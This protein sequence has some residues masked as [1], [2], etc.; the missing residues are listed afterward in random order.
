MGI[1]IFVSSRIKLK[2][3]RR[4]VKS[5]ITSM[6]RNFEPILFEDE[7]ADSK[8]IKKWWRE[9]IK[10]SNFLVLIIEKELSAAV[11]DEFKTAKE[12]GLETFVF[13]KGKYLNNQ[14]LKVINCP[15]NNLF[16]SDKDLGWFYENLGKYKSIENEEQ[17]KNEIRNAISQKL[18]VSEG[19]PKSLRSSTIK[20]DDSELKRIKEVYVKPKT[21]NEAEK[22]LNK[23]KFLMITGPA[24]VGKTTMAYF[25][26]SKLKENF[27]AFRILKIERERVSELKELSHSVIFFDDVFGKAEVEKRYADQFQD[28]QKL[29]DNNYLIL[30]TRKEILDELK[31]YRTRFGEY[32]ESMIK[33]HVIEIEQ[34]GSYSNEDLFQILRNHLNYYQKIGKIDE[35]EVEF[36]NQ[37]KGLIIFELRFPHNYEVFVREQ[38]KKISKGEIDIEQAIDNAKHIKR[39]AKNWFEHIDLNKKYFVFTVALFPGFDEERFERIY[40]K[41]IKDLKKRHGDLLEEDLDYLRQQTSSYIT[42]SKKIDFKHP[43]YLEGVRE[44]LKRCKRDLIEVLPTFK[45]LTKEK[46]FRDVIAVNLGE[47]GYINITEAL[48]ILKK[49][50]KYKKSS[51][52]WYVANS[53]GKIGKIKPDLILEKLK[54]WTKEEIFGVRW[55]VADSIGKFGKLKPKKALEILRE[56]AEDERA[57]VRNAVARSIGEIGIAIPEKALKILKELTEDESPVVKATVAISLGNIGK[58]KPK[59]ALK[60]MRKLAEY[61]I[62]PIK[63]SVMRSLREIGRVKPRVILEVLDE[64]TKDEN[65]K[66]R[67]T[68]A[69]IL[70]KVGIKYPKKALGILEKLAKDVINEGAWEAMDSLGEI[71]KL[72]PDKALEIISDIIEKMK[73][74]EFYE[75]DDFFRFK[76]EPSLGEIGKIIPNKVLNFLGKLAMEE[77][78]WIRWGVAEALGEIGKAKPDE[79]LEI[80]IEWMSSEDEGVR[81]VVVKSLSEIGK[82]KPNIALVILRELSKDKEV[83][84]REAVVWSLEEIGKIKLDEALEIFKELAKDENPEVRKLV[85]RIAGFALNNL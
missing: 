7:P 12:Y 33:D 84:I 55:A 9:K 81:W 59:E 24:N 85:K 23:K 40:L 26:S 73:K 36:A 60:I 14:E 37:L 25:L 17:F 56:L 4:W 58:F 22:I 29:K 71:G 53:L 77:D 35:K 11:F 32:P 70:G 83:W 28:I 19:L 8:H 13:P 3:E 2:E 57:P 20:D 38:L 67:R 74:K 15:E 50:A 82:V 10:D 47:F 31:N 41:I 43:N 42:E 48:E 80:L 65:T 64:W 69:E 79:T 34:E 51:A 21:F 63:G 52:S 66:V 5:A 54:E 16:V 18:E 61:D 6:G 45:Q 49:I 30:T 44:G 62:I 27:E 75:K 76:I 78:Y 1:K 46:V 39:V 72:M 68:V